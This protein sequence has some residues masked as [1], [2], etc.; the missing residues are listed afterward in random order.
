MENLKIVFGDIHG[1]PEAAKKAIEI[2]ESKNTQ[3]IFLGDYIDR[4][5]DSVETLFE[6]IK[7][8][9]R[10]PSWI[11]IKG[12]HEK[13]LS[14]II[15]NNSLLYKNSRLSN[16]EN[17]SY[18]ETSKTFESIKVS[19][20]VTVN[21]IEQFLDELCPFYEDPSYIYVH[22]ALN[23][24]AIPI[25]FKDE[26]T[27]LWN[28]DYQPEWTMKHFVHGHDRVNQIL[29]HGKGININT[30]CGFGGF[31]TGI[32]VDFLRCDVLEVINIS[33]EGFVLER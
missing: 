7:A 11:F 12:N 3:A 28:Y 2:A 16:G 4:G 25:I 10:N 30:N 33:E 19:S 32:V 22:S 29:Y 13:M 27:L 8:K 9:R 21:E 18:Y 17:F 24:N 1:C 14:E 31:L 20:H 26:E 15:K 6:L 5:P 23:N